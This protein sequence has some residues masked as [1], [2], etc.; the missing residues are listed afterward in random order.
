[1]TP[2]FL[3]ILARFDGDR[4]KARRYCLGIAAEYTF[5]N[6]TLAAEYLGHAQEATCSTSPKTS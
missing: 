3:A 4:T 1:M 5:K 6:R 2:T